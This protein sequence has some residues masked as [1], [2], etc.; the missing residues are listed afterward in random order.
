M[1]LPHL[2]SKSIFSE[3]QILTYLIEN[4]AILFKN[5]FYII[6]SSPNYIKRFNIQK[7]SKYKLSLRCS[8]SLVSTKKPKIN[9]QLL[10]KSNGKIKITTHK[11]KTFKTISIS[12][13]K[14]LNKIKNLSELLI[15]IA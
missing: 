14:K 15:F 1:A 2:T 3:F 8:S 11:F 13:I 4:L 9:V 12:A 5:I 6:P 10:N 7:I